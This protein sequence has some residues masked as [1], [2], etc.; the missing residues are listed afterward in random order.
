MFFVQAEDGIRD[1][2]V[3]GVQTCALPILIPQSAEHSALATLGL[4]GA[5]GVDLAIGHGQ[6]AAA[7]ESGYDPRIVA[8]VVVTAHCGPCHLKYS[9]DSRKCVSDT[10]NLST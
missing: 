5:D 2:H 10:V 3:T 1:G 6:C 4:R 8:L 7:G 9:T